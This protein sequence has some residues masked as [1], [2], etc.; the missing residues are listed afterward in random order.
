MGSDAIPG[1]DGQTNEQ[2]SNTDG[3]DAM[4]KQQVLSTIEARLQN[5]QISQAEYTTIRNEVKGQEQMQVHF[6]LIDEVASHLASEGDA[7]S[8][9]SKRKPT[10]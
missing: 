2:T 9:N 1:R 6:D 7:S 8:A 4:F 10:P 5:R 3:T